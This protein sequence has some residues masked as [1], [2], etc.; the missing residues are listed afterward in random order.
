MKFSIASTSLLMALSSINSA[1][2]TISRRA[3]RQATQDLACKADPQ[4]D[5]CLYNSGCFGRQLAFPSLPG[6][7][8][9]GRELQL[10]GPVGQRFRA[11]QQAR[12]EKAAAATA[13]RQAT[14]DLACKADPQ[15]D[16]CLYNSGCFGRQLTFN[17]PMG[18]LP[19]ALGP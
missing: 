8:W 6:F 5:C 17:G 18:P 1:D 2:A 11:R 19:L 16:C 14:Q 13:A 3:A 9:S 15:G 7:D 10:N 12:Q 4:G